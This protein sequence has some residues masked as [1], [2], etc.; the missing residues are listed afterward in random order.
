ME[1]LKQGESLSE[2][3]REY[4][5]SRTLLYLWTKKAKIE[6]RDSEENPKDRKIRELQR[7]ITSLEGVIGRQKLESDFFAHALRRIEELAQ[8]KGGD[9]ETPSTPRSRAGQRR[10]A[11]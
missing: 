7:K 9:G 2:L 11:D 1:R 3:A 10:K 8:Q 6:W 4:E 5:L